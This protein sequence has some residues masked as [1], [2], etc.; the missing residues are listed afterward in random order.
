MSKL[1]LAVK[2]MATLL[3]SM[4]VATMAVD[5]NAA[6]AATVLKEGVRRSANA[7]AT[8]TRNATAI[9]VERAGTSEPNKLKLSQQKQHQKQQQWLRRHHRR[10]GT[11][12]SHYMVDNYQQIF[13]GDTIPVYKQVLYTYG[14]NVTNELVNERGMIMKYGDVDNEEGE[15]EG[16]EY[17]IE[18]SVMEYGSC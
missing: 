4:L 14:S 6:A 15:K 1:L 11:K 8:A 2:V 9:A 16:N 7:E 12:T 18:R 3:L 10:M 5:L 17:S 13:E